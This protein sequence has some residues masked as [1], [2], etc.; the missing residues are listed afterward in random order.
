[1]HVVSG[2]RFVSFK[3]DGDHRDGSFFFYRA[4]YHMAGREERPK[5]KVAPKNSL[6]FGAEEV[7][8]NGSSQ[9]EVVMNTTIL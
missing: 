8:A 1:M 4:G 7:Y 2:G 6:T 9:L 5:K 3:T